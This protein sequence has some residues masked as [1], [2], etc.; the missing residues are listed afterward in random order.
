MTKDEILKSINAM[1]YTITNGVRLFSE[2]Q[3]F[4]LENKKVLDSIARE[5]TNYELIIEGNKF[6]KRMVL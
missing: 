3:G 1:P 4:K 2:W 6:R 5:V